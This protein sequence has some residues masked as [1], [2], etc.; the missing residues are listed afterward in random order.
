[1]SYSISPD[2]KRVA[3]DSP[4]RDGRF[5]LWIAALDRHFSPRQ[6]TFRSGEST[7]FYGK[8]GKLYFLAAEGDYNFLFRM[9]E[10]GSQKEKL[11]QEPIASIANISPDEKWAILFRGL[12]REDQD[13]SLEAFSL[14]GKGFVPVCHKNLC[15]IDWSRDGKSLYISYSTMSSATG[16]RTFIVPLTNGLSFR[17]LPRAGIASESDLPNGSHLK[18]I[19]QQLTAG[20]T[21]DV[22][23]FVKRD[24]HRNLYRVPLP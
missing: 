8:S 3:F 6:I 15:S 9:N 7:P 23:A 22:Y 21:A 11:L 16:G 24:V 20:P 4:E 10:D 12:K 2:E 5:R 19:D 18:A 14:E 17:N 13:Y 1:M